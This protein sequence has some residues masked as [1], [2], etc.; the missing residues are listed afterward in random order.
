MSGMA[1]FVF[2]ISERMAMVS[3]REGGEGEG[4]DI[5]RLCMFMFKTLEELKPHP[6]SSNIIII[7]S[8]LHKNNG[9]LVLYWFN[10]GGCCVW[11]CG[12]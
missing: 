4:A 7:F 11:I 1:A 12:E 3:G 9:E 6:L 10:G 2:H 5:Y 8:K